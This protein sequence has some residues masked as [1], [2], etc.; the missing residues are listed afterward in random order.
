MMRR[1][2]DKKGGHR[3]AKQ[4]LYC[5]KSESPTPPTTGWKP[6]KHGKKPCPKVKLMKPTKDLPKVAIEKFGG[7]IKREN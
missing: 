6:L 2:F 7:K 1:T 3:L 5:V 4:L